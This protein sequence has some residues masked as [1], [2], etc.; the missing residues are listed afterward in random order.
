MRLIKYKEFIKCK[1]CKTNLFHETDDVVK[2]IWEDDYMHKEHKKQFARDPNYQSYLCISPN[3]C[4]LR[5]PKCF[6][7]EI[8]EINY[9]TENN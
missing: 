1:K 7:S 3:K 5:C 8:V 2:Y 9:E 6:T 4:I